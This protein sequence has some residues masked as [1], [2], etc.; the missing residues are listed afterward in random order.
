VFEPQLEMILRRLRL[1]GDVLK[2]SISEAHFQQYQTK[3]LKLVE[4]EEREEAAARLSM[5]RDVVSWMSD[6]GPDDDHQEVF[7]SKHEHSN[8]GKWI[9][10]NERYQNWKSIQEEGS[11]I[12]WVNG[13]PGSGMHLSGLSSML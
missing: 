1:H 8:A 13:I 9:L 12:L 5:H 7:Y 3:W 11:S 6:G 10:G 4:E 2:S